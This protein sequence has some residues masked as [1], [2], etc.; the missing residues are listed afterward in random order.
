ML[1]PRAPPASRG[2]SRSSSCRRTS[3]CAQRWSTTATA[4]T[5]VRGRVW[6]AGST[7]WQS[8]SRTTRLRGR[9]GRWLYARAMPLQPSR[10]PRARGW[11]A[12]SRAC[13]TQCWWRPTTTTATSSPTAAPTS[14]RS[15]S[16]C[17]GPRPRPRPRAGVRRARP[18]GTA[19]MRG[20]GA[21]RVQVDGRINLECVVKDGMAPRSTLRSSV[22][23]WLG[24]FT[25]L[26]RVCDRGTDSLSPVQRRTA[27]TR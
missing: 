3:A 13:P 15:L 20:W 27:R 18:A 4:P 10:R 11:A 22:F 8:R 16:R 26:L 14:R 5:S 12:A 17:A 9:R 24:T 25:R 1:N 19:P 2:R 23:F 7:R 6:S 21:A